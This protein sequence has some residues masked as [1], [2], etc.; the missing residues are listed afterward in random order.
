[1]FKNFDWTIVIAIFFIFSLGLTTLYSVAPDFVSHQLIYFALGLAFFFLLANLDYRIFQGLSP[2]LYSLSILL[3]L[4]PFF[5]GRVTRG[6]SRWITIG[7]FTLQPSEVVKPLLIL[8]FAGWAATRNLR[9]LK[10]LLLLLLLFLPLAFLVFYQPALGSTLVVFVIF[11]AIVFMGGMRLV[12]FLI[13]LLSGCV[14]LPLG[15]RFLAD[16]QKKRILAFLN[17]VSDPLGSGYHLI[18]SKIAVGSGRIFGKGLGQGTQSHLRFLPE[19]Q[20]DFIFAALAEE[21]GLIG[22]L[23]LLICYLF[24]FWRILKIAE[25][26]RGKFALLICVGVFSMLFFQFLVNISMNIGL[27]PITGITLPLVSSGGS[28]L[29]ATLISL[30]LIENI[31]RV[32]RKR[33]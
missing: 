13:A 29:V 28:S 16:Y 6:A 20:S 1:M 14:L 2:I 25:N 10:N 11:L 15:G 12:H 22:S 9:N 5:L 27:L 30:G 31:A 4:S 24:L 18:Q 3:L 21:L 26:S 33:I 7:P 8:F 17:P 32:E 23:I 19:F